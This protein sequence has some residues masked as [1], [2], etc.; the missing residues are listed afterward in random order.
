MASPGNQHRSNCIGALS[1][2]VV[3]AKGL[4]I[5]RVSVRPSVCLSLCSSVRP[6]SMAPAGRRYRSIAAR[7]TAADA[8]THPRCQRT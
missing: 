7:H 3:C 2:P 5:C 8:S 4:C 1:F 6:C